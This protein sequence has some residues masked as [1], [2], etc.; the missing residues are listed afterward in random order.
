[1]ALGAVSLF[2]LPPPGHYSHALRRS[3]GQISDTNNASADL[4]SSYAAINSSG[5]TLTA[6][7]LNKSPNA[8][9]SAQFTVSGFTPSQVAAY[10]LSQKNPTTIVASGPQAWSSTMSFA[11]YS[12]TLLVV[13]GAMAK[14][15]AVEWDLNPDTVMLPAGGTVAL[16]PKLVSGSGTV[17]LGTPTFEAGIRVAVTQ[18][19]ITSSQNGAITVTAGNKPGFYYYTVPGTDNAG[20]AQEQS[21]W[22]VVGNP[23]ATFT[24]QGDGQQGAPGSTLNLSVT[25]NAGS[26]GGSATGATVFFT[27]DAGSLSS[28]L[29]TTDSSGNASVVLTLPENAGTVHVT[30]EGPYG[31]GHPEVVFTET[32]E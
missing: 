12:A 23:P 19:T 22:I 31:L 10:T 17:T 20:V 28:R 27:T 1:M 2:P 25:L 29:V 26:S 6:I 18:G 8:T 13:T 3:A 16:A 7:V 15:P 32:V 24:K 21:G 14:A 9:Y 4:F 30:A 5:T 11:P